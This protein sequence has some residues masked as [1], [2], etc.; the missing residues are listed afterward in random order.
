MLDSP[1]LGIELGL[2]FWS[3][4]RRAGLIGDIHCELGSLQRV[5]QHFRTWEV[6]SVLAVGDIADGPG[7]LTGT[8]ALLEQSQV[9]AVAG[10]HDRWLLAGEMRDLPDATPIESVTPQASAA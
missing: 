8:C 10:N 6:D 1:R 7:D 9:L 5:I 3:M 2:H 4:L